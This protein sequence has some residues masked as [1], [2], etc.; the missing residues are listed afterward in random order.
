[1]AMFAIDAAEVFATALAVAAPAAAVA[2]Q[3]A[4]SLISAAFSAALLDT[5]IASMAESVCPA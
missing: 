4:L 1:M 2:M 5:V 3:S